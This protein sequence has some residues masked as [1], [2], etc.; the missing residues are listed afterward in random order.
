MSSTV[1]RGLMGMP[2]GLFHTSDS[3]GFPARSSAAILAQ[4]GGNFVDDRRARMRL[5]AGKARCRR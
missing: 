4:S 2:S 3:T 5:A 1:Y